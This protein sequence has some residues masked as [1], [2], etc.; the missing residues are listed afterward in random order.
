MSGATQTLNLPPTTAGLFCQRLDLTFERISPQVADWTGVPLDR[1]LRE[2][3]L[4]EGL[5]DPADRSAV[6]RALPLAARPQGLVQCFR[7]RH[8]QTGAPIPI[9]EFRY[10]LRDE[11]GYIQAYEGLWV[12]NLEPRLR[13]ASWKQ[14]LAVLTRGLAHDFNNA[15][16]GMVALSEHFLSLTDPQHP[17]REGLDLIHQGAR[18]AAKLAHRLLRLH[19]QK[20]GQQTVLDLNSTV[21]E[22]G[23]LLSRCISKRA[24]LEWS[25]CAKPLPVQADAVE[26]QQA[27]CFLALN[28]AEAT[29]GHGKIRLETSWHAQSPQARY[30]AGQP[31]QRPVG[32]LAISDTGCGMPAEQ[33]DLI[34][35]PLFSTKNSDQALGLGLHHVRQFVQAHGGALSV[36]SAP[37]RGSTFSLWLPLAALD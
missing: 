22:L 6:C 19:D 24:Q 35:E 20:P 28:A 2:K 29:P 23:E 11:H 15:L 37:G 8:A 25:L 27:I 31:L 12:A 17:F 21:A 10:A 3:D 16:T 26:L 32:C 30:L 5:L 36:E 7:L 14:A 34:M 1:W 13:S 9:T 33:L 4:F 18:T